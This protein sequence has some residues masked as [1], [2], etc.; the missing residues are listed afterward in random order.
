VPTWKC[1]DFELQHEADLAENAPKL[2]ILFRSGEVAESDR[3]CRLLA[4]LIRANGAVSHVA[5]HEAIVGDHDDLRAAKMK[6]NRA[7]GEEVVKNVKGTAMVLAPN[8]RDWELVSSLGPTEGR[9]SGTRSP[10]VTPD[11]R[12]TYVAHK[13]YFAY[14]NEATALVHSRSAAEEL[15]RRYGRPPIAV[16]GALLP[17]TALWTNTDVVVNPDDLLGKL[18]LNDPAPLL[19][20]ATLTTAEYHEAREFISRECGRGPIKRENLGYRMTSIDL[21]QGT[22]RIDGAFGWYYDNLLTQ[23]AIEWE[24]RCALSRTATG[25]GSIAR[26]GSLA[27]RES[28]ES[29]RDPTTDGGGRCAAI[30]VSTLFVYSGADENL[31]TILRRRSHSVMVSPGL[32][33]IVPGGMFEAWNN[34]PWSVV[35]NIWTELLEEVYDLPELMGTGENRSRHHVLGIPPIP[36]VRSLVREGK[37]ELSVTGLTCNLLNLKPEIC[38][39]LYVRDSS[40]AVNGPEMKLNWEFVRAPRANN[41]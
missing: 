25:L 40:L 32:F 13:T 34:E 41:R 5:L 14:R 1:R 21:T 4:A 39:V 31:Y 37:A 29:G 38:T 12:S 6:I 30:T 10:A 33:H 24:L 11:E 7:F 36:L 8:W 23:Y 27:M 35:M 15:G 20:S 17:I 18:D 19:Q 26:P 2:S 28:V 3:P 9:V 16:E 22:P